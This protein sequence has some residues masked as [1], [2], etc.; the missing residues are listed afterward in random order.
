MPGWRKGIVHNPEE[1]W[2]CK[3]GKSAF[4]EWEEPIYF[5]IEMF[6][7]ISQLEG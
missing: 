2:K 7:G 4:E 6:E 1:E 3:G 5:T